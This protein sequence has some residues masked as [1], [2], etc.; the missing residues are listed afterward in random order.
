MMLPPASLRL[1]L[2]TLPRIIV[3]FV[4]E[5]PCWATV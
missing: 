3:P 4:C 1:P 2:I 5:V